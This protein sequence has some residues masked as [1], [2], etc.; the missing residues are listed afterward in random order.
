MPAGSAA[1]LQVACDVRTK[2]GLVHPPSCICNQKPVLVVKPLEVKTCC[3]SPRGGASAAPKPPSSTASTPRASSASTPRASAAPS[4]PPMAAATPRTVAPPAQPHG[5]P[6]VA[7]AA[8]CEVLGEHVKQGLLQ[9][10]SRFAVVVRDSQGHRM[11]HGGD[12]VR[13][14]SRG[15]GPLR[16]SVNDEG[17][18]S[19]TV[20]YLATVSGTYSLSVSC[21]AAPIPGSPFAITVEPSV[22]HAP[23][24]LADG[25]G[26]RVAVAG[27]AASFFVRAHDE[28]GRPKIMGGE[29]SGAGF[30][31]SRRFHNMLSLLSSPPLLAATPR[32]LS[33]PPLHD[34]TPHLLSRRPLLLRLPWPLQRPT[35][36]IRRS[37]P[38]SCL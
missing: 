10:A 33:S 12:K 32:R 16:P 34:L 20:S 28:F 4:R 9:A 3:S 21:N 1:K 29:V 37:P 25:A 8:M 23:S 18:G 38:L 17:D 35:R 30:C 11:R 26:L 31:C 14:S 19:Y 13:V 27:E 5:P 36:E 15:P 6:G 7:C 24:C 2:H 22:A